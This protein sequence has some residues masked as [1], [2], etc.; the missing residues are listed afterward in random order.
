MPKSLRLYRQILSFCSIYL[1]YTELLQDAQALFTKI[2]SFSN[3]VNRVKPS[4][5]SYSLSEL[6]KTNPAKTDLKPFPYT[7]A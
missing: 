3:L 7:P 4:C 5:V 6:Y 1:Y 2:Q